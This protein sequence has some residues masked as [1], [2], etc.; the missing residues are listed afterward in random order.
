MP[1]KA[2]G[3]SAAKVQKARPG[4]YGDGGGLYL[5]VRSPEAKFWIFRC[6]RGRKMRELGLGPASGRTAVSLSDARKKARVLYD[7]HRDGR[8]PLAERAAG[9][10]F[11]AAETAKAVTFAYAAERYIEAHRTG[12]RSPKHHQQWKNT[13]GTY[14]EPIIGSLSVRAIDTALILK[15]LEPI[16][17][18]KPETASRLRGRIELILDWARARGHRDGENPA[19]WRGHLDHLLPARS[20]VRR[21]QHHAA[22]PYA[23]L[24]DF[25]AAL[26]AQEG[27]V[28]RALEFTILTAART[29]EVMGASWKE[30]NLAERLWIVPGER[31]KAG[32]E[33]RAPLSARAVE[34]LKEMKQAHGHDPKAFVFAGRAPGRALSNMAFLMLLRRMDRGDLTAHGFRS[35]FRDWCAERTNFPNE[36]AAMALAHA[37]GNKVEAAYRRGDLFEKRRQLMDRLG[38]I[39]RPAAQSEGGGADPQ[40]QGWLAM[41]DVLKTIREYLA[42]D[43]A[44][45]EQEGLI[46]YDQHE[47]RVLNRIAADPRAPAALN[48]IAKGTGNIWG[49]VELCMLAEMLART[50]HELL[51]EERETVESLRR[52]RQSVEDLKEFIDQAAGHPEHPMVDWPAIPETEQGR[53]VLQAQLNRGAALVKQTPV[54][55]ESA[56]YFRDALNRIAALIDTRQQTADKV[57]SERLGANRKS[58]ARLAAENA[59][60]GLLVEGVVQDFGK[61]FA[62]HVAILAEV[63]L[64]VGE[65]SED[66]VREVLKTRRRREQ[67]VEKSV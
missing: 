66:R 38:D 4:R 27:T 1:R 8:D 49:L 52:H 60:I 25:M 28:A 59:A 58:A 36:V 50:F 40:A 41:S 43:P 65:V 57:L 45:Y 3:L 22:L 20:K 47:R 37:V 5:L 2:K 53:V 17:T 14:A 16:W 64:D 67:Q 46:A 31:M 11:Q 56:D 62:Q 61:P 18:K 42:T 12:W 7:L 24:P 23:E 10:A 6:V 21:V 19:R 29:G 33:H 30:I 51:I 34:I 35:S 55:L 32:K 13:I 26:R 48:V 63:V 15:V 9:R 54:E 39:L 44:D